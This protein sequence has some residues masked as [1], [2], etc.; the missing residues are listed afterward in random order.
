MS[1]AISSLFPP[2]WHRVADAAAQ[3]GFCSLLSSLH[4]LLHKA[5][6]GCTGQRLAVCAHC[7]AFAGVLPAL[8][9]ETLFGCTGQAIILTDI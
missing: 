1:G 6:F 4:A 8:L 2:A 3:Q 5:I 7:L 9:H